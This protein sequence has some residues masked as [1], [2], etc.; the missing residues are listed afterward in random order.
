[1]R[2]WLMIASVTIRA[3]C[4]GKKN[5]KKL[6]TRHGRGVLVAKPEWV[7]YH[8]VAMDTFRIWRFEQR[9]NTPITGAVYV[10]WYYHPPSHVYPDWSAICETVGDLLE[11]SKYK[12]DKDTG[13]PKMTREGGC[14]IKN[15]KQI[16]H[17]DGSRIMEIDKL[18]PRITIEVHH[19]EEMP[20]ELIYK[21]PKQKKGATNV[22]ASAR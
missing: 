21:E 11:E 19:Y 4:I 15:D 8:K 1:M 12:I 6:A 16:R 7:E 10:L 18:D 9:F 17:M 3:K 2:R 14:I 22:R 5:A 13:L 20:G